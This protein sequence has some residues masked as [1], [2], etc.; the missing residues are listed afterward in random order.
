MTDVLPVEWQAE[1]TA[2]HI[3]TCSF[4]DYKL[5]KEF[6]NGYVVNGYDGAYV[7]ETN[8]WRYFSIDTGDGFVHV[9][10]GEWVAK[11]G[12]RIVILPDEEVRAALARKLQ[13]SDHNI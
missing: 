12:G 3:L 13:A 2:L 7:Q 10:P 9:E 1:V 8:T 6:L 4:D 11:I 5:L